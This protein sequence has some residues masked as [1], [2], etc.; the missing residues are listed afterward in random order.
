M[1]SLKPKL[2]VVCG[3]TASGKTQ[4]A[5]EICRTL[6]GEMVNAD[7]RQVYRGMDI[8]T[9]K[10]IP[11][12]IPLHLVDIANPDE[13]YTLF[14]FKSDAAQVISE[15][16]A[17]GKV[18]VLVGGTGLWIDGLIYN[19]QLP[20]K[21]EEIYYEIPETEDE[22]VQLLLKVD[23]DSQFQVDLKNPRRVLRALKVYFETG[24]PFTKQPKLGESQYDVLKLA[25]QADM[26]VIER[27]IVD[28]TNQ[29]VD[30]GLV[31]EV[32]NLVSQYGWEHEAMTSIG[33]REFREVI[34]DLWHNP[35]P[36]EIKEIKQKITLHTRQYA[37]RQLTWFK[38]DP[39]IYWVQSPEQGIKR[40]S[41][42]VKL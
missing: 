13:R 40:A 32:A 30:S 6:N 1:K 15:I 11:E 34:G 9:N 28:R 38:R 18:P 4:L 8:G 29:M 10:E 33:Y 31:K 21:T 39:S 16:V 26:A 36:E 23:P 12:D 24:V 35:A 25:P 19:Y 3:T 5:S 37:K 20:K 17:R 14:Q 22:Q 42:F 27:K 41:D 7:S 2:I